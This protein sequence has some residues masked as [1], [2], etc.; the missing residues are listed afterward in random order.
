MTANED[1][2]FHE[3]LQRY[4]QA[5]KEG[6]SIYLE[7]EDFVDIAEYYHNEGKNKEAEAAAREAASLFPGALGPLTFLSRMA[8]LVKGDTKEAK[9]IASLIDDQTD[10][11]YFYLIAEISLVEDKPKKADDFLEECYADMDEEDQ[12]DF[13]IDVA[14]LYADYNYINLAA[15]WLGRSDETD[16]DDY[17]ELAGRIA[18]GRGK[19]KESED[20]F[21]K[22]LDNDPFSTYYWNQL[23]SSQFMNNNVSDSISSSEFSIAINPNDEE[24]IANKANGLFSLGNFAEASKYYERYAKLCPHDERA[25]IFLGASLTNAGNFE[26]ACKHYRK[27]I[28]IAPKNSPYLSEAYRQLAYTLSWCD[29]QQEALRTIE[30]AAKLA[31]TK[32]EKSYIALFQGHIYLKL[33]DPDKANICFNEAVDLA[34]DKYEME[35]QVG[36]SLFDCGFVEPAYKLFRKIVKQ[37][38]DKTKKGY[39]Y[40][41]LSAHELNLEKEY[42]ESL[43]KA[44]SLNPEEASKVL[45]EF[46]PKDMPSTDYYDYEINKLKK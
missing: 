27:A 10:L 39:S 32:E 18:F 40:L 29:H 24:A 15:K 44:C 2:H 19:F 17:R 7:V 16:A 42:L 1:K 9:R 20:I 11:E 8:M 41:A 30:K 45:G 14:T 6:K 31:E 4:E 5:Q 28:K 34:D 13:V 33:L 38:G 3:I 43:K 26:E 23:A 36:I 35:I 21:K 22:L 25:E 37:Y 46:F 12:K